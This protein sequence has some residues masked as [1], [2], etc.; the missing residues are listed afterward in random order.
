M[1]F[2]ILL[3]LSFT[4]VT[5]FLFSQQESNITW[6]SSRGIGGAIF[7]E[8]IAGGRLVTRDGIMIT[9]NEGV[10]EYGMIWGEYSGVLDGLAGNDVAIE[11]YTNN[12]GTAKIYSTNWMPLALAAPPYPAA[13][14]NYTIG[15]NDNASTII[16]FDDQIG[17]T[18]IEN[19][20]LNGYGI[21]FFADMGPLIEPPVINLLNEYHLV[22][23]V[24]FI[25][26]ASD[27]VTSESG[28]LTYQWYLPNGTP[29]PDNLG[30]NT[31]ILNLSGE[32]SNAGL[33]SLEVTDDGGTTSHNLNLIYLENADIGG[34][35]FNTDYYDVAKSD[36]Y[37]IDSTV[38][39]GGLVFEDG[40][41]AADSDDELSRV[42]F[43][44]GF[45]VYVY[46]RDTL[47][48]W[49]LI[50]SP[51]PKKST[52][53]NVKIND[54]AI[55]GD[56]TK[57]L[58]VEINYNGKH[59][60]NGSASVYK[61]VDGEWVQ[62]GQSINQIHDHDLMR[63]GHINYTG[64]SIVLGSE[65]ANNRNSANRVFEYD[66]ALEEWSLSRTISTNTNNSNHAAVRAMSDDNSFI[67]IDGREECEIWHNDQLIFQEDPVFIA[68][69]NDGKHLITRSNL[70]LKF[71]EFDANENTFNLTDTIGLENETIIGGFSPDTKFFYISDYTKE[72]FEIYSI[73][74]NDS[75]SHYSTISNESEQLVGT[76]Y[77]RDSKISN[78][79]T[80]VFL[81]LE[82]SIKSLANSEVM[83]TEAESANGLFLVPVD[84]PPILSLNT[85][86]DP[87]AG[88]IITIDPNP[89]G[90]PNEFSFQW[91]FKGIDSDNFFAIPPN[92]GGSAANYEVLAN[93]SN[94][95]TWKV[96]VSNETG[97]IS[98]EFEYRV[99]T[100]EDGDGLSD[101]REINILNTNPSLADTDRD[102]L[103]D[104]LDAFPNDP[105]ETLD[106]DGDG[107]GDNTDTFPNH[108]YDE[109]IYA[110][111]NDPA[112]LGLY[113]YH[114]IKDL[115]PGSTMIEVTGNQATVQLQME[116]SSDLQSWEDA[117][118]PA[119]MTIPADTDT[120]FFRFK[121]EE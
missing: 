11:V 90:Y 19:G 10:N 101:Y 115:R 48:Q 72:S 12:G 111:F 75:I 45:L 47:N 80:F 78:E 2:L 70:D 116:E 27:K 114:Q 31:S 104:K 39:S 66:N 28:T 18:I 9:P 82:T 44:N 29:Y 20:G 73:D 61:Y 69:A 102:G 87:N 64:D 76:Y 113:F 54:V 86:Y 99:F 41:Y 98:E 34:S 50:G 91:Y 25:L 3:I 93:E 85:L 100:D 37:N 74:Q 96:T 55:S 53:P 79:G 56:G 103:N 1:K 88:E 23:N 112:D 105:S 26:D 89:R 77:G 57:L 67:V 15:P 59:S 94:N 83:P 32:E 46:E 17:L 51:I 43:K 42:A 68:M 35:N 97:S 33:W 109:A 14:N 118:D 22:Q 60:Y 40:P 52:D 49:S 120:K 119:T 107:V 21:A 71:Y 5:S 117:G 108:T 8:P 7:Q 92:F 6:G 95:G 30:G 81:S 4:V 84:S 121:M 63:I 24:P 58:I 65:W 62:H 110:L 106:T 36:N 13:T 38:Y 16:I